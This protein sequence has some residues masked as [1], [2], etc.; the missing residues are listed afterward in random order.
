MARMAAQ[1]Q[2]DQQLN[3]IAKDMIRKYDT[4]ISSVSSFAPAKRMNGS[5]PKYP[6][7]V[8]K[9]P[10]N[11]TTSIDCPKHMFAASRFCSPFRRDTIAVVPTHSACAKIN[12]IMR[13]C[14]VSPTAAI[15]V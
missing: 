11:V 4:A 3:G 15:A 2:S 9:I 10:K 1:M 8:I 12:K 7:R 14:V 5:A 6:M 13:G